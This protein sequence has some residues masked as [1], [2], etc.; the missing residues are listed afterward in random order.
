M[1][2]GEG[3]YRP[4]RVR[5]RSCAGPDPGPGRDHPRGTGPRD[6]PVAV[7]P[8]QARAGFACAW[9]S[10]R[11]R[12]ACVN[13]RAPARRDRL[14]PARR[15]SCSPP[16]SVTR[17]RA[18]RSAISPVRRGRSGSCR[19]GID[20]PPE[21]L[22]G[23]VA[24]RFR[25]LLDTARHRSGGGARHRVRA[26]AG[27]GRL[28]DPRLAGGALTRSR[29]WSSRRSTPWPWASTGRTGGRSSIC[30]SSRSGATVGAGIVSGRRIHRGAQGMRG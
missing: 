28:L 30:C 17:A 23:L 10:S 16:M 9:V 13:R 18:W 14:Q 26:G 8:S 25:E 21:G 2:N 15:D 4:G 29:P 1:R 6:R 7:N 11:G 3:R 19:R 12:W 5:R 22:L 24:D 27:L 20:E